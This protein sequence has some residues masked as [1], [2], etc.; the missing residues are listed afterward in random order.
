M[1]CD[2][3]F[4]IIG[5]KGRF[6][7]SHYGYLPTLEESEIPEKKEVYLDMQWT[8]RQWDII[9]QLRGE[10]KHIH[11]ETHKKQKKKMYNIFKEE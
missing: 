7:G 11:L 6:R 10:V 4:C 5:S 3:P 2:Q 9:N 1:K 8:S